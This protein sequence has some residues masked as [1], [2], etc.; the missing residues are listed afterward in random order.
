MQTPHVPKAR[1][2]QELQAL[3]IDHVGSRSDLVNRLEQA[4]V[5][6][7]NTDTPPRPSKI[8]RVTRFP[9]HSSVLIGNGAQVESE[10]DERLVICNRSGNEALIQGNFRDNTCKINNCL[11]LAETV[12]L[13]AETPGTEG[14]IRMHKGHLYMFRE[15]YVYPG[16]YEFQF[17]SMLLV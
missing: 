15:N 9:N 12:A 2:V 8:D 14:D 10:T 13:C 11:Q 3:G 16:W 5:Y 17:G 1:L 4:G 6:E 7:L